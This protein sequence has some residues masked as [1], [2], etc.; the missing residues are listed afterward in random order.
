LIASLVA[1]GKT[2][3]GSPSCCRIHRWVLSKFS[4]VDRKTDRAV[5]TCALSLHL[6]QIEEMSRDGID[7]VVL[8]CV[9]W[10]FSMRLGSGDDETH[11]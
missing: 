10:D 2:L 4:R 5:M 11:S 9:A 6:R 3:A 8:E 7:N 1:L